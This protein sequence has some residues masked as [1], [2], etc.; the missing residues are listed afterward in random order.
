MNQTTYKPGSYCGQ[1][2]LKREDATGESNLIESYNER[3]SINSTVTL[4]GV[5][6][7]TPQYPRSLGVFCQR[8]HRSAWNLYASGDR[9]NDFFRRR[10][11]IESEIIRNLERRID[12]LESEVTF[13]RTRDTSP[14]KIHCIEII[15][16]PYDEVKSKVL[17]YYNSHG[18]NYPD[19]IAIELKIDLKTVIKAVEELIADGKLEVVV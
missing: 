3:I 15:D 7:E 17:A 9:F 1:T 6:I 2:E 14:I 11:G 12:E 13:L 10:R 8:S 19:D 4:L 5:P 18:E 16:T